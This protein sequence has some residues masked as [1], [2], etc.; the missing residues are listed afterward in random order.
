MMRARQSIPLAGAGL[1]ALLSLS[2]AAPAAVALPR[3]YVDPATLEP[4]QILHVPTGRLLTTTELVE[5][6][7]AYDAVYFGETH[8]SPQDHAAQLTLLEGLAERNPGKLALAM[9]MLRSDAQAGIDAWLA[10]ESTDEDLETLWEDN[11][12]SGSLPLYEPL[13]L[14]AR[15]NGIPVVALN[16]VDSVKDAVKEHTLDALPESVRDAVPEVD[17]DDP[18]HRAVVEAVFA[19]HGH[20][21]A[22]VDRFVR[23]QA[24]VDETMAANAAK[25]LGSPSG[26]GFQL[27]VVSGGYHVRH[28]FGIPRRLFRRIPEPF[29]VISTASVEVAP[30]KR[31]MLMDLELPELPLRDADVVWAV[32][33]EE[34]AGATAKED[35]ATAKEDGAT[36]KE[37]GATAKE[38]GATA[39]EEDA[40]AAE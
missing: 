28:G 17:L 12:S 14:Y 21:V 35:G 20:G 1:A 19:S 8:D 40:P 29:L 24:F 22:N 7:S 16:A 25:F 31:A 39:K 9:E 2:C 23:V 33:Y 34:A 15:D 38:D 6:A 13:L 11:W 5:L 4:G 36:A 32:R 10:G 37:D 3:Y 26:N 27:L 18:Y 30:E